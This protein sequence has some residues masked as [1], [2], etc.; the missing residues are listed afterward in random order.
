MVAGG[1]G[2]LPRVERLVWPAVDAEVPLVLGG[3]LAAVAHGVP[4]PDP[5]LLVH[6][7][8]SAVPALAAAARSARAV[9]GTPDGAPPGPPGHDEELVVEAYPDSVRV[10]V[11]DA[12]PASTLVAVPRTADEAAETVL[13]AAATVEELLGSDLLGPTALALVERFA[14]RAAERPAGPSAPSGYWGA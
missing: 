2:H 11:S 10:L 6:V 5:R 14:Q 8:G 9:L 4:V 13:V 3:E 12:V 7:R 1:L